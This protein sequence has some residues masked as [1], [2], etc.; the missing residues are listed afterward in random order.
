[1]APWQ[2]SPLPPAWWVL[3]R[4]LAEPGRL[5]EGELQ[6]RAVLRGDGTSK[7]WP[8]TAVDILQLFFFF[9]L[10]SNGVPPSLVLAVPGGIN[11]I[12]HALNSLFCNDNWMQFP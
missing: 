4:T 3:S 7:S 8:H 6:G 11:Y 5:V 2:G 12:V 1:M 10:H 9:L